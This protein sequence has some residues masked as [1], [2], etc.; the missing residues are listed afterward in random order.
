MWMSVPPLSFFLSFTRHFYLASQARPEKAL[1]D[2]VGDRSPV[3]AVRGPSLYWPGADDSTG[4]NLVLV[5]SA[6][7]Y[8]SENVLV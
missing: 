2:P 4:P 6:S 3:V 7:M 8:Q 1:A 5:R